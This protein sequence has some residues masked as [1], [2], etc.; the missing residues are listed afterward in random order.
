MSDLVAWKLKLSTKVTHLVLRY[1]VL[2]RE[3]VQQLT[4]ILRQNTALESLDLVASG[5]GSAGL[6]EIAPVLYRNTSIKSLGLRSNGLHDIESANVLRELIRRN[7]TI[8]SLCIAHNSF[9]ESLAAIRSITEGVRSNTTLQQLDLGYCSL[10]DRGISVLANALAIRNTSTLLELNLCS[11][12]ITSAGVRALFEESMGALK[13]LTKLCLNSNRI[14][15][16]GAKI[17]ADAL[18]RNAMPSLKRLDL[19]SCGIY[20]DGFVAM[21][22]ALEQNTSLQ[23]LNLQGNHYDERGFMALSESLPN[24]K[25]LQQIDFRANG[26][27][28]SVLPL[29]LEGFR[30]NCSLVKVVSSVC[31]RGEWSQEIKFLGHRNRFTPLLKNA[32]LPGSSQQLGIWPRALAKAATEPDILF[33]VLRNKP[34]LVRSTSERSR[35]CWWKRIAEKAPWL[36]VFFCAIIMKWRNSLDHA[37][38]N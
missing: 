31:A 29:L 22:S 34:K 19:G 18:G 25:G 37:I 2:S 26:T 27:F 10:G 11:N 9:G 6:A 16:E 7:K 36:A 3:N 15:S 5:L 35:Q 13:T 23:I 17:L 14:R 1:S 24:I 30:K 4:A 8:T 20:D 21:V 38:G 28:E 12:E 33:H 32:D